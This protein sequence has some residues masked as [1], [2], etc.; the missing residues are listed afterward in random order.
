VELSSQGLTAVEIAER[1]SL[2]V[3]TVRH[4]IQHARTKLGGV[5]KRQLGQL[6]ATA[7]V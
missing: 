2:S 5:T 1:L 4:H 3:W 7:D 6:F